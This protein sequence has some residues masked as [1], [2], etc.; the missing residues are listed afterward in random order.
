MCGSVHKISAIIV[1]R[2]GVHIAPRRCTGKTS[3]RAMASEPPPRRQCRPGKFIIEV[4]RGG[5]CDFSSKISADPPLGPPTLLQRRGGDG[6]SW[7]WGRSS[8]VGVSSFSSGPVT[9][10]H[11]QNAHQNI[12]SEN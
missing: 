5:V 2:L 9:I 6:V 11:M 10:F 7:W 4:F 3:G 8:V 12:F 1:V